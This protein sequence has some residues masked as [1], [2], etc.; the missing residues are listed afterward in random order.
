MLLLFAAGILVGTAYG[1]LTMAL[2]VSA[3]R[4]DERFGMDQD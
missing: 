2:V 1:V 4:V 3:S